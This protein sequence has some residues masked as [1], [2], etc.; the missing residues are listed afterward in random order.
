VN[1]ESFWNDAWSDFRPQVF[2]ADAI[3]AWA[4]ESAPAYHRFLSLIGD[5]RGRD[6]LD[7]GC[8]NGFLSVLLAQQGAKV[9]AVDT[10]RQATENAR[11]LAEANGVEGDMEVVELDA[12]R[13]EELG[14]SFD[15]VTGT[16][17]LHHI[18]PFEPFAATLRAVMAPGARGVFYENSARNR[19]LMFCRT[20]FTGRFGIPKY[21]DREEA[22]LA[23][24]EIA[25]LGQWFDEVVVHYPNFVF[26]SLAPT[27][28][29]RGSRTLADLAIRADE[30]VYRLVPR[31]RRY[32]YHQIIEIR[33]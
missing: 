18:E 30:A 28:L 25:V 23:P 31:L 1:S 2:P 27:Y 12:R 6:V 3:L 15:V 14:R 13:L 4:A 8:G 22:P 5:V 29:L 9:L 11:R 21:G 32:S 20:A 7:L 26:L 10:S 24:A 16:Y 19:L 33:R 17:V